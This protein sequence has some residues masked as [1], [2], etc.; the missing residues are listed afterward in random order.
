MKKEQPVKVEINFANKKAAKHFMSWLC[1]AGEQDYWLYMEAREG[2]ENGDITALVF[3]YKWKKFV[4]ETE[5]GRQLTE[6]EE[7]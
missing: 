1:E 6:S 7:D 5:C 2:E 4:I 3:D